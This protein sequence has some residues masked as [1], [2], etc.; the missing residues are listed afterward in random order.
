MFYS[1]CLQLYFNYFLQHA[2]IYSGVKW[3]LWCNHATGW[4]PKRRWSAE[5]PELTLNP[6]AAGS[7]AASLSYLNIILALTRVVCPFSPNAE[8]TT[9]L[10][11]L[12]ALVNLF[13]SSSWFFP[14][15]SGFSN[16]VR[17]A[18]RDNVT[19]CV[20]AVA[21]VTFKNEAHGEQR[22]IEWSIM[23]S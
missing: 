22:W 15:L 23:W 1:L 14:P 21:Y 3:R 18:I 5:C 7:A 4:K 13:L 10:H 17:F 20:L 11:W 8:T 16:R 12:A 2:S 19:F 9:S 6:S